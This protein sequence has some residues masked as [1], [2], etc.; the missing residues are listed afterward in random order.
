MY[1]VTSTGNHVRPPTI[2]PTVCGSGEKERIITPYR[3]DRFEYYL[4]KH[5]LLDKH[6]K[7]LEHLRR[8]FPIGDFPPLPKTYTPPTFPSADKHEDF[9]RT[10]L[11]EEIALGRVSGPFSADKVRAL[12]GGEFVTSPLHVKEKPNKPGEFRLIQ[13]FSFE[14][15]DGL[16]VNE[17][18]DPNDYPTRWG[19]TAMVAEIV[20]TSSLS[21]FR[22]GDTVQFSRKSERG[23]PLRSCLALKTA[24]SSIV[25][26]SGAKSSLFPPFLGG[27]CT[28]GCSDGGT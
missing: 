23:A 9:I 22:E 28:S 4:R 19:T 18:I 17:F 8:G 12:L 25:V 27:N 14:H 5:N 21:T 20:S 2:L 24:L 10:Y 15:A 16:V 1:S 7:L 13:N 26:S 6:P 11:A 3:A